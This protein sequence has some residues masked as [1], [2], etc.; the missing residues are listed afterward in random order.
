[1]FMNSSKMI[2]FMNLIMSTMI[3]ISNN[4][5]IIS[6]MLMEINLLSFIP[7]MFNKNSFSSE[8]LMKYFFIQTLASL[9]IFFFIMMMWKYLENNVIMMINLFLMIK[10]GSSPFHFWYIQ[11]IES[12]SWTMFFFISTWQKIMPLIML[13]YNFNVEL[14][15]MMIYLN[16]IFSFIGGI[17]QTSLRKIL[18]YSSLNHISWMFGSML[19]NLNL[20]IFYLIIYLI[21]MLNI[22]LMLNISN[23]NM[24]TQMFYFNNYKLNMMFFSMIFFSLAGIPP[25]LG[26]IPKWLIINYL[27]MNKFIFLNLFMISSTLIVLFFYMNMMYKI[28]LFNKFKMKWYINIKNKS[29]INLMMLNFISIM[30]IFFMM[31]IYMY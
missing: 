2:I 28:L 13:S 8:S 7:L 6:W 23:I 3:M 31:F 22:C 18:G 15:I 24:L 17:N 19:M 29:Y 9:M 10:L 20:M 26:F 27:I 30:F 12:L 14:L 1:M 16:L 4:S 5:W 25:F 11:I 21:M